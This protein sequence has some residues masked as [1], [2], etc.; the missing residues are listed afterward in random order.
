MA[1]RNRDVLVAEMHRHLIAEGKR[2]ESHADERC[3]SGNWT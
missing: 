3:C 1:D 2:A